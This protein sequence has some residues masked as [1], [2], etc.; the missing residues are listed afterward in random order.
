M[1]VKCGNS[2]ECAL[3]FFFVVLVGNE[4]VITEKTLNSFFLRNVEALVNV[5][6]RFAE[7]RRLRTRTD[8]REE[9]P[10]NLA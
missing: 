9:T 3:P 7:Y 2:S 6:V 8:D 4:N 5:R 1:C 10:Q